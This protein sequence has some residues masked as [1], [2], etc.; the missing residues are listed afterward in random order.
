MALLGA[1]NIAPPSKP[2]FLRECEAV[3][4]SDSHAK[5]ITETIAVVPTDPYWKK[6]TRAV[7]SI[8]F[9]LVELEVVAFL[10][11]F[12]VALRNGSPRPTATQTVPLGN[13][14]QI[15]YSQHSQKVLIDLLFTAML[16]GVPSVLV[17]GWILHFFLGVRV[18]PSTP[19]LQEW[20]KQKQRN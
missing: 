12:G 11:C 5:S 15:L 18:F 2:D 14:G 1:L 10:Y 6:A 8:V 3:G 17:S 19:T 4:A 13:P 7:H 20:R 9:W 16:I